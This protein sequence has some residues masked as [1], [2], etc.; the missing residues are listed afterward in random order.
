MALPQQGTETKADLII[1]DFVLGVLMALPQQG[2]ETKR[3]EIFIIIPPIVLMALPQQGTETTL[4][5]SSLSSLYWQVLMAL[6]QQGT[7]TWKLNKVKK[8]WLQ[9]VNGLTPT[10]DGNTAVSFEILRVID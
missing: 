1:S 4:S 3:S 6:P 9:S 5:S 2:T 8:F 7:E 10:G